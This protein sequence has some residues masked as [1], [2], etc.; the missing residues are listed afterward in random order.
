MGKTTVEEM[1]KYHE[2]NKLV[3]GSNDVIRKLK[4]GKLK[5][6]FIVKNIPK[7]LEDDIRH[8]SS[9]S[10]AEVEPVDYTNDE[11]G[12]VFKRTHVLLAVGVIK[13]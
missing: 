7:V 11:F 12:V 2:A 9:L 6:V 13:D 4:Q 1:K 10:N 3:F 8:N 5:K